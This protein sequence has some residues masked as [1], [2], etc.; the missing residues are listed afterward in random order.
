M[1]GETTPC[2]S[3]SPSSFAALQSVKGVAEA[4]KVR[5]LALMSRP[6]LLDIAELSRTVGVFG[7]HT[8]TA[9]DPL[10]PD[11]REALAQI[12]RLP[13]EQAALKCIYM[14]VMGLDPTGVCRN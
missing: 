4:A 9:K 10:P 1:S 2:G 12:N 6:S 7:A 11:L 5:H 8:L 3:V 14:A 13:T